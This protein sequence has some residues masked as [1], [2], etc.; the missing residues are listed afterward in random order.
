MRDGKLWLIDFQDALMGPAAYDL[1]ALLRDSYVQ[2]SPAALDEL[3][4]YYAD[5]A[6]RH[7]PMCARSSTSSRSRESSRTRAARM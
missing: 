6:Q 1:V 4:G 2:L 3:I 7:S 5:K